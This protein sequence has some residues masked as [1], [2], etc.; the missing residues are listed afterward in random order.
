MSRLDVQ[1]IATGAAPTPIAGVSADL[2]ICADGG[3]DAAH[4]AGRRPDIVVGDM[5]SVSEELLEALGSEVVVDR[6]PVAKDETDLELALARAIGA[7]AAR[8]SVHLAA[9]GRLDHQLANL[10]VL[11]SSRWDSAS[12]D[13][14]VGHDPVFVIRGER[15]LPLSAGDPFAIVAVGGPAIVTTRGVAWELTDHELSPTEAR[16]ISNVVERDGPTVQVS[17][18]VVLAMSSAHAT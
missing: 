5:D 7:G 13:A 8:I 9:G 1:V 15:S 18:G 10:A 12:L 16:G 17:S 3:L 4:A 2:I 11:A 6:L 14:F